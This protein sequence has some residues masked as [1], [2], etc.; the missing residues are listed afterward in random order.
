VARAAIPAGQAA[1]LK[2]GAKAG[3]NVGGKS[4]AGTVA[5]V[6]AKADG[7]YEVDVAIPRGGLVAGMAATIRL[8]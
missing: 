1:G 5:A 6:R 3:V 7:R 4:V 8:P 2:P